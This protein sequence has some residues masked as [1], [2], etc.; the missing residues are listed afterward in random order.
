[1]VQFNAPNDIKK[2]YDDE[3]INITTD[4][5]ALFSW[6]YDDLTA[7]DG[8]LTKAP[9]MPRIDDNDDQNSPQ[10][11]KQD[12][13]EPTLDKNVENC[14]LDEDNQQHPAQDAQNDEDD[15]I[16]NVNHDKDCRYDGDTQKHLDD[17]NHI[18]GILKNIGDFKSTAREEPQGIDEIKFCEEIIG[19]MIHTDDE[20]Y[21]KDVQ[22]HLEET[23]S[24]AGEEYF[25]VP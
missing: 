18:D 1:M 2:L 19:D 21:V 22:K 11:V 6:S 23:Y 13:D 9:S 12:D 5:N 16:T 15:S 20:S 17:K 3:L 7:K 14:Q 24:I 10:E 4:E 8:W 25:I